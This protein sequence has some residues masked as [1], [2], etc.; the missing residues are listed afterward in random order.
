M[1]DLSGDFSAKISNLKLPSESR[2]SATEKIC[3]D[4]NE[5]F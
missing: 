4:L 2:K 5:N 1:K 3:Q